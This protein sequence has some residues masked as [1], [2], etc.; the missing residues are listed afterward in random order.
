MRV[1]LINRLR[2]IK[3]WFELHDV[4]FLSRFHNDR[5][6]GMYSMRHSSVAQLWDS[7]PDALYVEPLIAAGTVVFDVGANLGS[8]CYA[9]RRTK[10]PVQVVAFEPA[11]LLAQR[12]RRLFK[13][14]EVLQVA[15]S[16][17]R[18]TATFRVPYIDGRRHHS[19]G[20]LARM[21]DTDRFSEIT[22]HT[23]S[24]DNVFKTL[25]LPRLDLV[26]IDV[27]GH[28]LE[29]IKGG[30]QTLRT[31]QPALLVEIEQRHHGSVPIA[32]IMTHIESLGYGGWF[33]NRQSLRFD[34]LETFDIAVHQ[35]RED[36]G[37]HR[38]INNFLFLSRASEVERLRGRLTSHL[39]ELLRDVTSSRQERTVFGEVG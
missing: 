2:N 26:K 12:L 20:S 35:R 22:V 10:Q 18:T 23:D 31:H 5:L 30:E 8:F 29:V 39:C 6:F 11:P 28:E 32:H 14:V 27:E 21:M 19:R 25:K 7:D 9:V 4:P 38:Y 15:L 3:D 37:T 1:H 24:L 34:P 16:D 36:M 33:L 13:D 17:R